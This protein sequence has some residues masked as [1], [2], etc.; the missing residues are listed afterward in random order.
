MKAYDSFRREIF[1]NKLTESGIL[2][3]LAKLI[4]MCL[5]ESCSRVRV[6]KQLSDMFLIKKGLI[7]EDT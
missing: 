5:N 4:K 2:M 3:Y 7:Q 1:Y 6:G